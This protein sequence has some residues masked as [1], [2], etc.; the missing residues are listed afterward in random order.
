M[1]LIKT[2]K[3]F[4]LIEIILAIA[5]LTTLLAIITINLV[6][7]SRRV[8]N[9][10]STAV[11]VSD[12]RTQQ[13]KAM[14]GDTENSGQASSYGAYFETDKYTLFRGNSYSAGN[15]T[16]FTV[17]LPSGTQFSNILFPDF[18]IVFAS[19]SGEIAGFIN[20]SNS[21]T[22][23]NTSENIQKNVSLNRFG[24]VTSN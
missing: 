14:T 18:Q 9:D 6:S 15:P 3:G 2:N 5:V 19:G 7:A 23:I 20:G 11:L 10:T 22:I 13:A 12:L 8:Y 16:N 24:V 17:T 21:I 1:R 4:S